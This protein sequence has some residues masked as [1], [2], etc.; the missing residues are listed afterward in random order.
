MNTQGEAGEGDRKVDEREEPR[1]QNH[2]LPQRAMALYSE[3]LP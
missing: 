3:S 1:E 2:T